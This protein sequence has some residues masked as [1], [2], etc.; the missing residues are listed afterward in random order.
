MNILQESA[1]A[2]TLKVIP[3]TLAADSMVI[4]EE[5]TS[6]PVTI[7]ITPTV[8]D[9]YLNITEVFDI[10]E[11]RTYSYEI[12]N[13]TDSVFRGMIYCTNQDT[14]TF[15]LNG[16]EFMKNDTDNGFIIID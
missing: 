1:T 9:F 13:G 7:A 10:K 6:T 5:G 2:Q 4:T 16:N 11:G 8:E 15:T 14:E 12:F 3:R